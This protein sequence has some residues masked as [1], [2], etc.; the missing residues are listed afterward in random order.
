MS[1]KRFLSAC[2]ILAIIFSGA[3]TPLF[4]PSVVVAA[5]PDTPSNVSPSDNATDVSLMPTLTSSAFT[6]NDT[7]DTHAASQW[8]I[9][10][11]SDNY[12]TPVFD[13]GISTAS[14]TSIAA[15]LLDYLTTYYWHVRHQDDTGLW[16]S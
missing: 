12:S 1:P 13:S 7:L 15:P 8:Q 14:L 6:D 9:T 2:L 11:T 4:Q 10:T 5:L 3:V 16:S